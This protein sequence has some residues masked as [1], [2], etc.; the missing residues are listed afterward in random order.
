MYNRSRLKNSGV[1]TGMGKRNKKGLKLSV[2]IHLKQIDSVILGIL[3]WFSFVSGE[4]LSNAKVIPDSITEE[5]KT[6]AASLFS[7]SK[8]FDE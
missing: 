8:A 4:G 5:S 6:C 7:A 2:T 1:K 3:L